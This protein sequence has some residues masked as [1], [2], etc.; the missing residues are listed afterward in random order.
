[1]SFELVHKPTFTNQLLAIPN[2]SVK[3]LQVPLE[4]LASFPDA[5]SAFMPPHTDDA[6]DERLERGHRTMFVA[7]RH[8]MRALL[9][10]ISQGATTLVLRGF[11]SAYGNLGREG[12]T[13]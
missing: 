8:A 1:M 13:G 5:L 4:A 9:V 11:L 12:A 7:M 10:T 2:D 3:R 6:R